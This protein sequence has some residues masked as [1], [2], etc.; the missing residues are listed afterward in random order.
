MDEEDIKKV[1]ISFLSTESG[2]SDD[3]SLLLTGKNASKKIF[4]EDDEIMRKLVVSFDDDMELNVLENVCSNTPSSTDYFVTIPLMQQIE[5]SIKTNIKD[6]LDYHTSV[7]LNNEIHDLHN[8]K[9]YQNAQKC[10]P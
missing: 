10:Y 1:N 7:L 2:S 3:F 5:Q 9:I 8:A 6:I 4:D